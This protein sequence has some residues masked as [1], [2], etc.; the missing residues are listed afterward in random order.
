MASEDK[1]KPVDGVITNALSV[2][3]Q[4]QPVT[5][6][7]RHEGSKWCV[8][9]EDGSHKFGCY[10][11]KEEAVERLRQIEGHKKRTIP[12]KI[13]KGLP[14]EI[15]DGGIHIHGLERENSKSKPDGAHEHVFL[16]EFGVGLGG[17]TDGATSF[18]ELMLLFTDEAGI[19][20]HA[21]T[22]KYADNTGIDGEHV[23][24]V[25]LPDGRVVK[26]SGGGAHQHG[27]QVSTTAFDG[28]HTHTLDL[29]SGVAA[30]SLTPSQVWK[31]LEWEM[32][33]AELPPLPPASVFAQ[34]A[35]EARG[36]IRA[37][38]AMHKQLTEGVEK[39]EKIQAERPVRIIKTEED[40]DERYVF[41]VVLIPGDVDTQGDTYSKAAV[42]KAAHSFME[43]YGG[44]LKLMHRGEPIDEAAKVLETYI[45]K[46]EETHGDEIFPAG[47]WFLASRIVDDI[48]WSEVKVG[49]WDGYS[50]G[51]TAIKEPLT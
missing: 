3:Q 30:T 29:D 16:V 51:G 8:Y 39:V 44:H 47:T 12:Q 45:S 26:T 14:A 21:L 25:P 50:M 10:E 19:H 49:K 48:L 15:Y 18:P 41:G 32:P 4:L 5:K 9:S 7:I 23:H 24:L 42:Q 22:G 1:H 27:L 11:T 46:Q 35:P 38:A 31:E 36:A 40:G 13:S 43:I 33:Q 17:T 34:L 6:T 28:G 37:V 20:E 2:L